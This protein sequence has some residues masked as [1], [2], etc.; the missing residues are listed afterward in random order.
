MKHRKRP[1]SEEDVAQ[2]LVEAR[3]KAPRNLEQLQAFLAEALEEKGKR[4][5]CTD[6]TI[7]R[8]DDL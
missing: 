8:G 6:R 1:V 4:K 2:R 7:K 5:A 3:A